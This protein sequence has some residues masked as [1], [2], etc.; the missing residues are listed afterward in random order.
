[1]YKL[2]SICFLSSYGFFAYAMDEKPAEQKYRTVYRSQES[3]LLFFL[4]DEFGDFRYLRE[5]E[6]ARYF[7]H[8]LKKST[9]KNKN[10]TKI[11]KKDSNSSTPRHLAIKKPEDC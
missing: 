2:L 8:L 9:E 3:G 7:P 4:P 11:E 10:I 6:I 1:M 5:E